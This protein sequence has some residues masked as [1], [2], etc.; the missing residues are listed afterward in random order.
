MS[1]TSNGRNAIRITGLFGG[2]L[3]AAG[4]ANAQQFQFVDAPGFTTSL[5]AY[6]ADIP[7]IGSYDYASDFNASPATA[8]SS[9]T[10]DYAGF[11]GTVTFNTEA[12]SCTADTRPAYGVGLAFARG[13][14]YF[15]VASAADILI[16]WDFSDEF[17]PFSFEE[18]IVMLRDLTDP[19]T[20]LMVTAG[21]GAPSAGSQTFPLVPGNTYRYDVAAWAFE[22]GGPVT[23]TAELVAG[24]PADCDVN[25]TLNFDDIDCFV[26][27]FLGGDLDAADLDGNGV[28]NFDDI[29]IFVASFLEGCG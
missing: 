17:P 6:G 4:V 14:A 24:C 13:Y 22:P 12:F 27:G 1:T 15:T 3:C 23:A 7:G 18:S 8:I 19:T 28:I 11:G 20:H 21:S 25:G 10:A 16:T 29:D 26:N 9:V 2:A 5:A